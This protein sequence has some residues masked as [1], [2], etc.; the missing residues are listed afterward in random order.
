L[1]GGDEKGVG[2]VEAFEADKTRLYQKKKKRGLNISFRKEIGGT[3]TSGDGEHSIKP[4]RG[5]LDDV[6]G[7]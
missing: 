7:G 1:K 2:S 4:G 3:S 5:I 6:E